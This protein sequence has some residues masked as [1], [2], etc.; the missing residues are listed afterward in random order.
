MGRSKEWRRPHEHEGTAAGVARRAGT[1]QARHRRGARRALRRD[2]DDGAARSSEARGGERRDARAWR[3]HLQRGRRDA[4]DR[5]GARPRHAG[6]KAPARGILR[7][8]R[9]GGKRHLPR[10]GL[11]VH[12]HRASARGPQEYRHPHALARRH[13]YLV[14][15]G[16]PP[17]LHD[18]RAVQR[19]AQGI[20]RRP[21]VPRHRWL[22]HRHGVPRHVRA[23]P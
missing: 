1:G 20:F 2:D 16:R 15:R 10:H 6:G 8:A 9:A 21:H 23:Q 13:E 5:H 11:D 7:G 22:P 17:D 3:R 4:A 14:G 19:K 18:G 12:E